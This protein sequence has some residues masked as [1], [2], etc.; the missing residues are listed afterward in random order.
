VRILFWLAVLDRIAGNNYRIGMLFIDV[1]NGAPR[2]WVSLI[3][4]I[5]NTLT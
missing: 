5:S 2:M 3:W 4:A 1:R